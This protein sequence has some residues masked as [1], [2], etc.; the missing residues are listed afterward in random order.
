MCGIAGALM[1]SSAGG[2]D[3]TRETVGRMCEQM[4]RRGP[5]A[6]GSWSDDDAGLVLGHRRLSILDLSSR[7]DQPMLSA[8]GR[9]VIVYNGE[10]YNFRE[11]RHDLEREGVVFHTSS[12]TEVLLALYARRGERM[13]PML[14]GMFALAIWD[15]RT[16]QLFVARDPYGIKPLYL[17]RGRNGWLFASQVKALLASGEVSN[18]GDPQGQASFWLLGSVAE[19]QTWFRDISALPAGHYAILDA[20]GLATPQRYADIADAWRDAPACTLPV[21]EIRSRVRAALLDSV[22][23]HLVAD[24]PVGVFLS[25]GIDSGSLA[26]LMREAGA[27]DLHGVTVAFEEFAGSARDEVP[28]AAQLAA[29][30][31]IHHHVRNVTRQEFEHDL[32]AILAAMDQ[33][34]IDGINTWYASKAVAELGLK[35]VVSGVGGDE[36]F[37]GYSSFQR[38][39]ALMRAWQSV[40]GMPGMPSLARMAFAARARRSGNAR[41]ALL[42][43]LAESIEGAWFLSRSSAS[44]ADLATLM[45]PA[46]LPQPL[47]EPLALVRSIAGETVGDPRLALGQLESTGYLRN[48][49]LRDSDWASMDHSVELRTPLVDARLLADLQPLLTAFHRFP[50]KQLLTNAPQPPLPVAIGGRAKTGFGT[51]VLD[52]LGGAGWRAS[53]LA[54]RMAEG[55][56]RA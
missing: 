39:P 23:A 3:K 32:P 28:V 56:Y 27:Q 51:P 37:Q 50:G 47:P 14:R 36:L 42:P 20:T 24:V 30:Y 43:G 15:R 45:S 16:Q 2:I 33:P 17:A 9:H 44:P 48:Q 12:D 46:D 6:S 29:R 5:D 26:A 22:R 19:P 35:V 41:W 31:G 18:E 55:C 54:Q 38:L 40:R 4:R 52:W 25:G 10:I 11:L 7:A 13:L 8:D 1:I 49:L 34:S 53:D 21:E